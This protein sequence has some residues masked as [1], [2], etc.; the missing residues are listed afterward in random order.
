MV[1]SVRNNKRVLH[2]DETLARFIW[3]DLAPFALPQI[4]NRVAIGLNEL[5]RF[6]RYEPGEQFHGHVD[7]SFRRSY[8]EASYYTFMIYLNDNFTGGETTF[9]NSFVRA[10]QGMALIF[11]HSLLHEGGPVLEG[12]K[13]VL[14]SDIMYALRSY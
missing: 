12:K 3:E 14:R 11:L 8:L 6:Y 5:F 9:E 13:Y 7:H 1:N 2:T 10:Q 4:D